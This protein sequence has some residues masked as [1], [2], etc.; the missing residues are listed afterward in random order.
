MAGRQSPFSVVFDERKRLVLF[1]QVDAAA[2]EIFD[3]V[4]DDDGPVR[5][6]DVSEGS[7]RVHRGLHTP[8]GSEVARDLLLHGRADLGEFGKGDVFGFGNESDLEYRHSIYSGWLR[9]NQHFI[10]PGAVL[11]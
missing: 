3:V 8:N 2:G 1:V 4:L 6:R 9:C 10:E 5:D 7:K 11:I